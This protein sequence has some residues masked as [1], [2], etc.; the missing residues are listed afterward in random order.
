MTGAWMNQRVYGQAN[1]EILEGDFDSYVYRLIDFGDIGEFDIIEYDVEPRGRCG[2]V[3]LPDGAWLAT[4][5]V[6]DFADDCDHEN[7]A[8]EWSAAAKL[9]EVAAAFQ[10]AIDLL[11]S[12]QK[13]L[14]ARNPL[15]VVTVTIRE[16]PLTGLIIPDVGEW[17]DV[18]L[19]GGA[20]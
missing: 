2:D 17:R 12:H 15:R 20:S 10:Q 11:A 6:D 14:V 5:V 8:T 4:R 13:F 9:P 19:R 3:T 18:P 1:D 7:L 16:G